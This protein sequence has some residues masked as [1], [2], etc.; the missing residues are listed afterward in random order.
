MK[1]RSRGR[2][3]IDARLL[4]YRRGGIARY[5][6]GLTE[7]L[8]RVAPDLSFARVVNRPTDLSV[9]P[10]IR[11]RTPPHFLFERVTLGTELAFRSPAL[12][13]STDFIAPAAPGVRRIVTV[14]DLAFLQY[15]AF[16]S[17]EA[18]RYY[19]QIERSL[20]VADRVIAVSAHTA[21]QL[22]EFTKVAN[23]RIVII[24]NGIDDRRPSIDCAEAS[25][26]LRRE[27]GAETSS[28]IL[29]K[30]PVI[31]AVGTIE[32]RKR[33]QL[34]LRAID[35]PPLNGDESEPLLVLVGQKGWACDAIVVDIERVSSAGRVI[36][37][38]DASDDA[39]AALYRVATVLAMPSIDEGFGLPLLE[40]MAA[41][42]P[43]VAARRGALP[44]V[45]ED[46]AALLESDDP[47]AWAD[48]L[49]RIIMDNARR[50]A[51]ITAGKRRAAEFSW[52]RTARQTADVYREVLHH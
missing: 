39:L 23:D 7:W 21:R 8:P 29:A 32:P 28:R 17:K 9:L 1:R 34:L 3:L 26:I 52:E 33:Q 14:H 16:L 37:L 40:A 19:G 36:W 41:G 15:P 2:I 20:R 48:V 24:H 51:L 49:Q 43:V 4:A 35:Q 5:I 44:E 50:A 46:A 13:H 31:L 47:A 22:A 18:R 27:L 42:L 6:G 10:D 30:R 12:I 25:V 45:A 11:V 38:E